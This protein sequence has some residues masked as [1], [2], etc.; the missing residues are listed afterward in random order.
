MERDILVD[1]R[2]DGGEMVYVGKNNDDGMRIPN[3]YSGN[4]FEPD[5]TLR[6]FEG[7]ARRHAE[8]LFRRGYVFEEDAPDQRDAASQNTAQTSDAVDAGVRAAQYE[9]TETNGG[10]ISNE[11]AV[12]GESASVDG[13]SGVIGVSARGSQ[14]RSETAG[15]GRARGGLLGAIFDKITSEEILLGA[16]ILM[17]LLNG[18]D[19]ELLIMLVILLFC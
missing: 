5:G 1:G 3:R 17:L 6:S 2:E 4:A 13:R 14:P 11:S 18:A 8:E 7:D 16:V 19:D 15:I 12:R 9:H 10:N